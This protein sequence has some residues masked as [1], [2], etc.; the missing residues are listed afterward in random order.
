MKQ[1]QFQNYTK[2]DWDALGKERDEM[3]KNRVPM[4]KCVKN[5]LYKLCCRNLGY[6]VYNG[7]S[8]F[9]GLRE[10]FDNVYLF[11]EYHWDIGAPYG[12]VEGVL[13]LGV[14]FDG[15]V[16]EYNKDLFNWLKEKEKEF[17]LNK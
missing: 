9:V 11:T 8:G 3:K 2:E 17:T 5:R 4:D 1:P 13:D 7:D 10:K 15:E 16:S 6:G 12:T 14:D